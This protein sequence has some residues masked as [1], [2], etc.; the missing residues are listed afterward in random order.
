VWQGREGLYDESRFGRSPI[1]FLDIKILACLEKEPLHPAHSFPEV[2]DVSHSTILN[3]LH[4]SL[5]MKI[6]HLRWIPHELTDNLREIRIDKCCELFPILAK[7]EK[8]N[9]C[10]LVTGEK[11]WFALQFQHSAKWEVS[12]DNVPQKGSQLVPQS[13]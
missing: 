13:L 3:H 6:F 7:L 10:N 9:F 11:S 2:L 4:D 1:D 12:R 5:G 8:G